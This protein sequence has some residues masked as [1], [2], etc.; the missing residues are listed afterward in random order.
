MKQR[1]EALETDNNEKLT[2]IKV[3]EKKLEVL[4]D[5]MSSLQAEFHALKDKHEK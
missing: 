4:H 5:N 3:A 1:I 2:Q